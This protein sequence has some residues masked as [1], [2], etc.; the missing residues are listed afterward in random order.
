MLAKV[1]DAYSTLKE[2]SADFFEL[3]SEYEQ[4]VAQLAEQT[5]K[6]EKVEAR[7]SKMSLHHNIVWFLSGSGVLLVGILIGISARRQRRKS[8]L[9]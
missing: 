4:V 8:S 9:L 7:L 5:E 2:D 3:K 1:T 6:A